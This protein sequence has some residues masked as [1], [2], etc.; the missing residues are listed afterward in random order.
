MEIFR[1]LEVNFN[2]T[3][4][5]TNKSTQK[6]GLLYESKANVIL[7]FGKQRLFSV[8]REEGLLYLFLSFYVFNVMYD[9]SVN[10]LMY[11]IEKNIFGFNNT[12]IKSYAEMSIF[13]N[14]N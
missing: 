10:K 3:L 14:S 4:F 12:P 1:L 5:I 11:F 6:Y 8:S 2:E 9:K 7:V 13:D